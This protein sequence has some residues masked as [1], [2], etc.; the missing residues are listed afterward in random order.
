[1]NNY[2]DITKKSVTESTKTRLRKGNWE[3]SKETAGKREFYVIYFDCDWS[4]VVFFDSTLIFCI[5]WLFWMLIEARAELQRII[6]IIWYSNILD[7]K[8]PFIFSNRS[9]CK[10]MPNMILVKVICYLNVENHFLTF[11]KHKYS[12]HKDHVRHAFGM[13]RFL[14]KLF[15]CLLLLKCQWKSK[16]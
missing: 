8:V 9:I 10:G 4:A 11:T 1:M 14:F 6:R 7:Q 13:N 16:I 5:F 2:A 12:I 3:H 15:C